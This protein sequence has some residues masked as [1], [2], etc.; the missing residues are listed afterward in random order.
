MAQLVMR[1][2]WDVPQK[3]KIITRARRRRWST[4]T[5]LPMSTEVTGPSPAWAI[6]GFMSLYVWMNLS[7]NNITIMGWLI[8]KN[9]PN[10]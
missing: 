6:G 8:A 3:Q 9:R 7:I 2:S 10:Q 4:R 5:R 1:T